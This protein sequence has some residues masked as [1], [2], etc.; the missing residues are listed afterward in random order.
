MI[1]QCSD[2][3]RFLIAAVSIALLAIVVG[4]VSVNS[5]FT[6]VRSLLT[7]RVVWENTHSATPAFPERTSVE[8]IKP[9]HKTRAGFPSNNSN[10]DGEMLALLS[11]VDAWLLDAG[12]TVEKLRDYEALESD[13]QAT[14][15][16]RLGQAEQYLRNYSPSLE[17]NAQRRAGLFLDAAKSGLEKISAY[18]LLDAAE[19]SVRKDRLSQAETYLQEYMEFPRAPDPGRAALLLDVIQVVSS[20][21]G[22]VRYL[23]RLPEEVFS[24]FV[25]SGSL[26]H[27]ASIGVTSIRAKFLNSLQRNLSEAQRRLARD[28]TLREAA[29]RLAAWHREQNIDQLQNESVDRNLGTD[30]RRRSSY[31]TARS[32]SSHRS[33]GT[34]VHVRAYNRNDGT[35]VRSHTRSA[36]RR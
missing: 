5:Y 14:L 25:E 15:A 8:G 21:D 32:S 17:A 2:N 19:E 26:P 1:T 13:Q 27:S 3:R 36:P 12:R 20:D 22:A 31:S 33:A 30:M 16:R 9:T 6:R 24:D 23:K 28:R 29:D 34:E 18:R 10:D 4:I 7:G 35:S 11:R